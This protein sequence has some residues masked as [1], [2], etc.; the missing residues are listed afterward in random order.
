MD[1]EKYLGHR[2]GFAIPALRKTK[3]SRTVRLSVRLARAVAPGPGQ[4]T[5]KSS[6]VPGWNDGG[7]SLQQSMQNKPNKR[8]NTETTPAAREGLQ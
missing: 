1:E 8:L 6:I 5:L 4:K 3:R 2:V 7:P